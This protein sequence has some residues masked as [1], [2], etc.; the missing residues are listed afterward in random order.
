MKTSP[1]VEDAADADAPGEIPGALKNAQR[2][3]ALFHVEIVVGEDEFAVL[4]KNLHRLRVGSGGDNHPVALDGRAQLRIGEAVVF[5]RGEQHGT[6]G[7]GLALL[8][9]FVV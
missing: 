7:D 6:S 9:Q 2:P 3:F 5:R 4:R 1:D 8:Q